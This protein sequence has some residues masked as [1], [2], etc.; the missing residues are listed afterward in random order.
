VAASGVLPLRQDSYEKAIQRQGI[1][2]ET[3][4]R[5]FRLGLAV[6]PEGT[7]AERAPV[8]EESWEHTKSRLSSLLS[9][10]PSGQLLQLLAEVERRY[11]ERLR[12]TLGEAL[13]RLLDYQDAAYARRYLDR[14]DR[15]RRVEERV[16]GPASDCLTEIVARCLAVWMTYEDAIRVAQQKIRPER[17]AR[18]TRE[19]GAGPGQLL[20]VTDYLKPDI[21]EILGVLPRSLVGRIARWAERRWPG[22]DKP[23]FGQT[24][25]TTS[26]PGF[27]RLWLLACLRPLRPISYRLS[28][29]HSHIAEY[30]DA[31]ERYAA[32]NLDLGCAVARLAQVVKGYGNVRR[33]TL[34]QFT[35]VLHEIVTPLA[36]AELRRRNGFAITR[37]AVERARALLLSQPD[38]LE[39]ALAAVPALLEQLNGKPAATLAL[40]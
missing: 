10:Q 26:F 14:L 39:P 8:V 20:T 1:A 23:T 17:F 7:T 4:L 25:E 22:E 2:V 34:R 38:S 12:R 32:L 18:I 28:L 31:V 29:E 16:A 40:T 6:V 3:N 15:I 5:A 19:A 35:R 30:L 13:Y 33:R 37:G 21:Q 27:L 11:P 9:F 24:L 36:E